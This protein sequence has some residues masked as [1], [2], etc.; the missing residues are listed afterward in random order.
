MPGSDRFCFVHCADLHLD[1]PFRGLQAIA[2]EVA[3]VLRDASITA[4]DAVVEL[5]LARRAAFDVVAGDVY[6]GPERGLRAQLTFRPGLARLSA[7]GVA[8]FVVHG[9]HDPLESGWSAIGA[10]PEQVKVFGT[11]ALEVV[12]VERGGEVIAT[13][14]G[15]SYATRSTSENLALR[16]RRPGGS[17][18][19]AAGPTAAG[20]RPLHVGVLHCNVAGSGGEHADYS[21]CTLDD[22]RATG[23]DYLALG[24]VHTRAVLAEGSGPGD[25][26]VV[27][28]GNTQAHSWRPGEQGAKGA[29]VVEVAGGEVERLEFVA[30]VAVRVVELRCSIEGCEDVGELADRLLALVEQHAEEAAGR[31]LVLRAER[32]GAAPLHHELAR[33]GVLADL[34]AHL[35]AEGGGRPLRWWDSLRDASTVPLDLDELRRRGDFAGELLVLADRLCADTTAG[36][37]LAGSVVSAL[38]RTLAQ[39]AAALAGEPGALAELL[40]RAAMRAL[41]ELALG[42]VPGR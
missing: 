2:P 9:N 13:V 28:P 12:T 23:L 15:V 7:G 1:T 38:P 6:D 39:R 3:E 22:L 8:S 35:R 37:A 14:Q 21:P 31:H 19:S 41:D 27:Y 16:L 36:A 40:G 24:H 34:L 20:P 26:W 32:G 42:A 29:Y 30:C 33:P 25:P 10:W 11:G 4:F 18:G 17:P 5:A